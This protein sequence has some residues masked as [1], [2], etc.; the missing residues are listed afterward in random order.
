MHEPVGHLPQMLPD[1]CPPFDDFVA[2]LT[3]IWIDVG[4][5]GFDFVDGHVAH[6]VSRDDTHP[7]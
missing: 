6:N 3:G 5:T 1:R 4:T 2:F 7:T